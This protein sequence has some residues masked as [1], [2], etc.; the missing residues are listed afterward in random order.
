LAP[1]AHHY[2][3][4]VDEEWRDDPECKL[5]V[6]NPFGTQ[7]GVIQ[8]GPKAGDGERPTNCSPASKS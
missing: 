7:N 2:R 8:I 3:F 4:V 5:R 6:Q 1:G